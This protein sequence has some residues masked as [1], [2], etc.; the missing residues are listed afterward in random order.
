MQGMVS[1]WNI[2]LNAITRRYSGGFWCILC[3]II[4]N[5]HRMTPTN[6]RIR[7]QKVAKTTLGCNMDPFGPVCKLLS[8]TLKCVH[9]SSPKRSV[10]TYSSSKVAGNAKNGDKPHKCN[11]QANI[12]KQTFENMISMNARY[13]FQLEYL[14]KCYN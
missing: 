3:K 2:C 10:H 11:I 13:G 9:D 5:D 1:N 4:E 7:C 6:F 14:F 8:K 12:S